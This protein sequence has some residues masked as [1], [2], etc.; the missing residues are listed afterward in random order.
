[1]AYESFLSEADRMCLREARDHGQVVA[2]TWKDGKEDEAAEAILEHFRDMCR[3]S[4]LC[5]DSAGGSK[6]RHPGG[7]YRFTYRP[8]EAGLALLAAEEELERISRTP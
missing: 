4:L 2:T 6:K 7:T 3:R 8:T 1:M 5:F